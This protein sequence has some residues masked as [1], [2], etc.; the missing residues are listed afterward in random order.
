MRNSFFHLLTTAAIALVAIFLF[1]AFISSAP[2]QDSTPAIGDLYTTGRVKAAPVL[3]AISIPFG[4]S[5]ELSLTED[6]SLLI[7]GHGVCWDEGRMFDLHVRVA[8]S[9]TNAFGVG[10]TVDICAGG[11]RQQWDAEMTTGNRVSFGAGNARACAGATEFALHGIADEYWW[12]K[13]VTLVMQD[14]ES[15]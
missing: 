7:T 8:Q 10:Q 6:G 9:T 3:R 1:N 13:D 15:Q 4:I 2:V 5:D 12:C 14:G 11:E